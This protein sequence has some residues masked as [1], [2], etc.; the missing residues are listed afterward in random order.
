M[1]GKHYIAGALLLAA[2]LAA[3]AQSAARP[4]QIT[5]Q[6]LVA[7]LRVRGITVAPRQIRLLADIPSRKEHPELET[8][9]IEKISQTE[10]RIMFRC[11]DQSSC[12]PFYAV[13]SGLGPEESALGRLTTAKVRTGTQ[14]APGEAAVKRGSL[15]T[16]E[17][18]SPQMLITLP[19][20]C[21]QSGRQGE[22]IAVASIDHTRTYHAEIIGM[23]RLR[24]GL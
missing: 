7:G 18:A 1:P 12:V 6:D 23:G 19:V 13:V 10:A 14:L 9:K 3:S 17:I 8:L 24:T 2:A 4:A 15:A 16:L 20:V 5:E 21:L 11:A 22:Q